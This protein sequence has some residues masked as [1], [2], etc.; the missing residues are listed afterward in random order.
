MNCREASIKAI[1]IES[2]LALS[3]WFIGD[4]PPLIGSTTK[5]Q[6]WVITNDLQN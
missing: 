2:N 4:P 3:W 1:L 6:C 5:K